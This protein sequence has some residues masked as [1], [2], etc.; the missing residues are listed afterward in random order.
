MNK[1][2]SNIFRIVVAVIYILLGIVGIYNG[3]LGLFDTITDARPISFRVIWHLAVNVAMLFAGLL[4]LKRVN[5]TVCVVLSIVLFLGF[6]V[7]TVSGIIA[8]QGVIDVAIS[9]AETVC[10]FLFIGC[11]DRTSTDRSL[12]KK[13]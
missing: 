1:K 11:V 7:N 6:A 10:S 12:R 9:A 4:A 8:N 3:V 2:T 5:K 13:K